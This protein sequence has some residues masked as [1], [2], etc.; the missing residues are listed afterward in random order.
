MAC[1]IGTYVNEHLRAECLSLLLQYG[2]DPNAR[3]KHRSTALITAAANGLLELVNLLLSSPNIDINAQDK[4]GW[5]V[6]NFK[7]CFT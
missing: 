2:A 6:C 4:E 7:N 1:C 5:T 3:D